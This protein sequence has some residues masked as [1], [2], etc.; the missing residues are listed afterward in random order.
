VHTLTAVYS[1]DANFQ[2][3]QTTVSATVTV[4]LAG[5]TPV[6]TPQRARNRHG[7]LALN[8]VTQVQV[9]APGSGTPTGTV[10]YYR[11]GFA[12]RT[13]PVSNGTAILQTAPVR[14]AGHYLFALYNGDANFEPSVSQGQT[15]FPRKAKITSSTPIVVSTRGRVS[16][17][18]T[19]KDHATMTRPTP[20][21][22][23]GLR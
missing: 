16:P 8:L 20:R 9:T 23:V 14:W 1:G 22:S 13:V 2:G 7:Q 6:V 18:T 11:D 5:T 10:T 19:G 17:A 12:V 21:R 15:V 3:S 4:T